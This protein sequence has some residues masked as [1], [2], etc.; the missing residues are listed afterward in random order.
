MYLKTTPQRALE[1]FHV[2]SK[3]SKKHHKRHRRLPHDAEILNAE[4]AAEA[5]GVSPRLVLRLAREGKLPGKK[6]GKEWRFRRSALLRW[7]GD[8]E[9]ANV[10][11]FGNSLL[12][13][14][15]KETKKVK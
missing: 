11:T 2:S 9:T 8:T 5:L 12:F 10:A 4:G 13:L 14:I 7:L 15:I 1:T 3:T 6:V